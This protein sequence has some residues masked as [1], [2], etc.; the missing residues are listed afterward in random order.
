MHELADTQRVLEVALQHARAAGARRITNVHLV[1]GHEAHIADESVQFYWN[2]ISKG[3][4]ADG[5]RLHFRYV[6]AEVECLE[7]HQ[8]HVLTEHDLACP[9]CGSFQLQFVAGEEFYVE[10]ID[11]ENEPEVSRAPSA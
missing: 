10:A 7:C 1:I 9:A 4:L 8:R 3:T 5:S 11:V 6:P 2:E